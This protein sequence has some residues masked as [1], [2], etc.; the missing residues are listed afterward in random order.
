MIGKC[1]SRQIIA[2]VFVYGAQI[3]VKEQEVWRISALR[4]FPILNKL[5]SANTA[6][7]GSPHHPLR[8]ELLPGEALGFGSCEHCT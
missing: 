7:L 2:L 8:R 4:K 5:T 6:F 1:E 3:E